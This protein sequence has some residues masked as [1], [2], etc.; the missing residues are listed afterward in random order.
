MLATENEELQRQVTYLKK[1]EVE[2]LKQ[3]TQI[4]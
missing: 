4:D 1:K 2:A 3:K